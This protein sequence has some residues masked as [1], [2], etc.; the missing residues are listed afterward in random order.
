MFPKIKR[1]L[2]AKS[3]Q[4]QKSLGKSPTLPHEGK[5]KPKEGALESAT[6]GAG[7]TRLLLPSCTHALSWAAHSSAAGFLSLPPLLGPQRLSS[8]IFPAGEAAPGAS[9]AVPPPRP[10]G[11]AAGRCQFPKSSSLRGK[12][13]E[14][15]TATTTTKKPTKQANKKKAKSPESARTPPR[16]K[17]RGGEAKKLLSAACLSASG[18]LPSWS[19]ERGSPGRAGGRGCPSPRLRPACSGRAGSARLPAARTGRPGPRRD[20][21]SRAGD[22]PLQR[23]SDGSS[24]FLPPPPRRLPPLPTPAPLPPGSFASRTGRPAGPLQD[25]PDAAARA[26][27]GKE[28]AR[29]E[30]RAQ[31][32]AATVREPAKATNMSAFLFEHLGGG[33]GWE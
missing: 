17:K 15:A 6:G 2:P 29:G 10:A 21:P 8:L 30:G 27:G 18:L 23:R 24:I 4:S 20:C 31:G 14:R 7:G 16:K 19:R 32:P 3:L 22:E 25:G 13:E 5:R 26:G 9:V 11:S 12:P 33:E 1:S 28:A